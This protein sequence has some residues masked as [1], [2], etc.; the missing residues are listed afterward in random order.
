VQ[1]DPMATASP[2]QVKAVE[3]GLYFEGGKQDDV[4]LVVGVI[5]LDEDSPSR[6]EEE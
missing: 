1:E 6:R 4:T 2:F 3:E 5:L